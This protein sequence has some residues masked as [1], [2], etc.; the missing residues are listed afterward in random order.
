MPLARVSERFNTCYRRTETVAGP[1][2]AKGLIIATPFR[3]YLDALDI[4]YEIRGWRKFNMQEPNYIERAIGFIT[5]N[6]ILTSS[7]LHAM[8]GLDPDDM[9]SEV[10]AEAL[11]DGRLIKEGK[12]WTLGVGPASDVQVEVIT[13]LPTPAAVLAFPKVDLSAEP[14]RRAKQNWVQM[15]VDYLRDCK[16]NRATSAELSRALLVNKNQGVSSYIRHG[17]VTGRL[18]RSGSDWVLGEKERM[19]A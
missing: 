16:D 15:A 4:M 6:G 5:E 7:Q 1:L 11:D 18:A 13:Y 14:P 2:V 12:E 19:A 8:L 17:L 10:L 3:S 9:P